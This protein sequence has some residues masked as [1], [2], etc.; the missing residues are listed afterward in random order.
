MESQD[1][2]KY[3]KK[4]EYE[5]SFEKDK[6]KNDPRVVG[7]PEENNDDKEENENYIPKN[8]SI[9]NIDQEED[10]PL[11]NIVDN[12]YFP[13]KS[14]I[15]IFPSIKNNSK[16]TNENSFLSGN[17][18]QEKQDISQNNINSIANDKSDKLLQVK[19]KKKKKK[20]LK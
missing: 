7:E 17:N 5:E 14:E 20:I 16:V 18:S 13:W 9:D 11:N 19:K 6:A 1:P 3:E 15:S 8:I 10:F 2:D 4:E 12:E